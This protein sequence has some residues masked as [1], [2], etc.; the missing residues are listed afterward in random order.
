MR[1]NPSFT[2]TSWRRQ[3]VYKN[4][5]VADHLIDGLRTAGLPEGWCCEVLLRPEVRMSPEGPNRERWRIRFT[6]RLPVV[7]GLMR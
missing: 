2:I 4:P 6:R 3:A 5:E 7:A 1:I